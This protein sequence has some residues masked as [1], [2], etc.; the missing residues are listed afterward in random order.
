MNIRQVVERDRAD[1]A[2]M[3][4]AL[5]QG[6]LSDH[7]IEVHN[8]FETSAAAPIV[9]VAE[10]EGRLVGFLELDFRKYAPGCASSPVPFIED[11]YVEPEARR[12]PGTRHRR[13]HVGADTKNLASHAAHTA[14][15]FQQVERV[16]CFRRAI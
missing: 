12:R 14:L 6:S 10:S 7:E 1:C 5:W 4:Q 8:H 15:G 13:R 16:V 11:R 3:R 9:F 2:R